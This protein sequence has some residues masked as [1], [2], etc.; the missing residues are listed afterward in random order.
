VQPNDERSPNADVVGAV[1][2]DVEAGVD[3][4][5]GEEGVEGAELARGEA[6]AL[7]PRSMIIVSQVLLGDGET[8]AFEYL[9]Y[10]ICLASDGVKH[11]RALYAE[12][13]DVCISRQ[14]YSSRDP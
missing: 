6:G 10:M 9:E 14:S 8:Y 7:L 2:V 12:M 4:H 5:D 3:L 1:G 11:W 13:I